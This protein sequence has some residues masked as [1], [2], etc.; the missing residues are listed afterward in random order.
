MF[1]NTNLSSLPTFQSHSKKVDT[2]SL[3]V[4]QRTGQNIVS[5]FRVISKNK[6][7]GYL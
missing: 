7:K 2:N 6:D 3:T 5:F 1:M 4:I